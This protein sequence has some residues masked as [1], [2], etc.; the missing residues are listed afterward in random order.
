MIIELTDSKV[1]LVSGGQPTQQPGQSA[2]A[3]TTIQASINLTGQ[4]IAQG[5]GAGLERQV[6]VIRVGINFQF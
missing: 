1:A 4:V 6:N 2:N 5:P 3:Q